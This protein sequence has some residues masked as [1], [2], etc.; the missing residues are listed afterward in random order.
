[1]EGLLNIKKKR[2][3]R[4]FEVVVKVR[5]LLCEKR[6]GHT[7]TLDESA[8]GV[9]VVLIGRATKLARF[10]VCDEKE[11]IGTVRLGASTDTDDSTG[12]VIFHGDMSGVEE[13]AFREVA[14]SFVGEIEQVPPLYSCVR[15]NGTR[16]HQLA[17][18]GMSVEP[19]ARRVRIEELEVLH[20]AGREAV[21]RVV[22][23]KGTYLRA[24]ARDI[25]KKLGCF[26]HLHDL[27][28]LRVGDNLLENSIDIDSVSEIEKH[29][30]TM[31][32]ALRRYPAVSLGTDDITRLRNGQRVRV[33][34]AEG[35]GHGAVLRVCGAPGDMVGVGSLQD[36]LLVPLKMLN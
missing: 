29:V 24:L 33:S 2:G 20:F 1:M 17:R 23:S 22:C 21:I 10:L 28:R 3:E 25:G 16:L 4:S 11:Y 30:I 13:E 12:K 35:V 34:P 9:L 7:G 27:V 14:L 31:N 26:G 18:R 15:V 19:P 32:D 36:D 8:L 5:N 6:V